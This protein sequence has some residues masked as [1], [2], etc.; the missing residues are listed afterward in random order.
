MNKLTPHQEGCLLLT[1]WRAAL[2]FVAADLAADGWHGRY[3]YNERTKVFFFKLERSGRRVFLDSD[4]LPDMV[5]L[6]L[7]VCPRLAW[8]L[9]PSGGQPHLVACTPSAVREQRPR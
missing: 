5:A 4:N 1:C 9:K 2:A 3:G 6:L 7:P 8:M